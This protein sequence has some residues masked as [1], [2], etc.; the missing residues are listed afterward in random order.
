MKRIRIERLLTDN[1]T[2]MLAYDQGLEHGP[3]DFNANNI[4]PEFILHI[5]EKGKFNGLILQKGV[6]EI[7][8]ENYPKKIPLIIKLN[9]RTNIPRIFPVAKQLCSVKK[10]VDLGADAVGYTIYFG[11]PLEPE[12]LHEFGK[13]QE[14]AHDYGL[15]VIAWMYPRGKFVENELSTSIL[16]YAARVGMEL[17]A[18]IVKMKYNDNPEEYKWIVKCAGKTKVVI[19]G[20]E[21]ST[22]DAEFLKKAKEIMTTGVAGM[23]VGRNIWQHKSPLKMAFALK[24][25]IFENSTAEDAMRYLE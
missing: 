24:K 19:A 10:A 5:A 18:D 22:A 12:I 21:K 20:G 4:D 11:S 17:G 6:A 7:Y 23:A 1:R 9:G 3:I 13:L 16:A 14:E 8:R 25:I 15:P 2:L